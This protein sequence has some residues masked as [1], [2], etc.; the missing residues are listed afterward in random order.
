MIDHDVK[1]RVLMEATAMN[2]F[3]NRLAV[4]WLIGQAEEAGK[5]DNLDLRFNS[6]KM[7]NKGVLIDQ[8]LLSVGSQNFHW[9][10]W[11]DPSLTE[12]NMATDDPR[13]VE[14]FLDEFEYWWSLAI[15][16]E[17]DNMLQELRAARGE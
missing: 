5:L 15:P 14:G 2:G 3:E 9:S 13:A 10:A 6:N 8:E 7:H 12:Y 11:G 4:R 16:V 1:L 17:E